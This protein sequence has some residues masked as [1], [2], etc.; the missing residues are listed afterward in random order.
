MPDVDPSHFPDEKGDNQPS[1]HH[2]GDP[3]DFHKETLSVGG[4][5]ENLMVNRAQ[6]D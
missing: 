3:H 2:A 4:L 5:T 1:D 6:R